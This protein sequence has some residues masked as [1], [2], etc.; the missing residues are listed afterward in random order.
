[1]LLLWNFLRARAVEKME[2]SKEEGAFRMLLRERR[3][4][5]AYISLQSLRR[6][7]CRECAFARAIAFGGIQDFFANADILRC[8]FE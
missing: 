1:M 2:K 6:L 7:C 5:F 3:S 8:D 4:G